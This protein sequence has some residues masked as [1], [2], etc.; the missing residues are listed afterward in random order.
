MPRGGAR[1]GAGRKRGSVAGDARQLRAVTRERILAL[2]QNG[3]DPLDAVLDIVFDPDQPTALRM[4]A[5]LGALPFVHPKLSMQSI[6]SRSTVTK[7]DGP[8]LLAELNARLNRLA[9]PVPVLDGT[10]EPVPVPAEG[11]GQ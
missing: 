3:R 4:Q 6:E 10:A 2:V 1:P 5:A 9:A 11:A 8:A 7:V